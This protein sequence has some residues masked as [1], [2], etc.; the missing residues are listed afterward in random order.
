M[1]DDWVHV[2]NEENYS[3][4]TECYNY[5]SQEEKEEREREKRAIIIESDKGEKIEK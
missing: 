5:N 1:D 4:H 3:S 2:Q